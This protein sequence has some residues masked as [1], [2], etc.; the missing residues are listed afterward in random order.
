MRSITKKQSVGFV[1]TGFRHLLDEIICPA[2]YI[3][4][5]GA[6]FVHILAKSSLLK[7]FLRVILLDCFS[8]EMLDVSSVK[9]EKLKILNKTE[10][11]EVDSAFDVSAL[12]V[13]ASRYLL[14]DEKGMITESPKQMF[15]RIALLVA[16]SD[17]LHDERVFD[18][19][20]AQEK[21]GR[22]GGA[23]WRDA[24]IGKYILNPYHIDAF[25][26][27]YNEL[28]EQGCM[29]LEPWVI[30]EWPY[31]GKFDSYAARIKE[32]YD[33]MVNKDFLPN[34][35]TLMNAGAPLGQLSACFVLDIID[36]MGQIMDTAK[37][38]AMIFKSG[39]GVG[40]NYSSLR[41]EGDNVK[42]TSGV[43]SGPIS[44]MKIV[45]AVTD[46]VKQGGKRRGA[47]MGLLNASHPDIDKFVRI[48]TK[49]GVLENFNISMCIDEAFWRALIDDNFYVLKNPRTGA[50]VGARYARTVIN[51]I[52]Q[53]AWESAE[54]GL[55]FLD[56]INAHNPL[57]KTKGPITVCNPCGEQA[58]HPYESCNLGSINLANFV[59]NGEFD[60]ARY[61]AVIRLCTRFLDNVI[62]VNK[63]PLERI[64][65]ET[66]KTRRIGLGVMGLAD[67][68]FKLNIPYNDAEGYSIMDR[69][70]AHLS[71][72]SM[73][74]SVCL[75]RTRGPYPLFN[76]DEFLDNFPVAQAT[77]TGLKAFIRREGIRNAWTTTV[78][79]TGTLSMLANCSS[80]IEPVF[81]LSFEKHVT[82]GKFNYL[83]EIF[84]E[85]LR[86][87]HLGN[88]EL[89]ETIIKNYGSCKGL[90]GIPEEIQHVFVTSMDIHWADHVYAEAVWQKWISNAIA[91]T[92][93]M[94]A[95]ATHADIRRAY[96]LAH[97]LGLKGIT[98]YRDGSRHTQVLNI[99][100]DN[101][102]KAFEVAPSEVVKDA[103]WNLSDNEYIKDEL[104]AALDPGWC[105]GKAVIAPVIG[106]R[107]WTPADEAEFQKSMINKWTCSCGAPLV[108]SEGCSKCLSCNWSACSSG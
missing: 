60:W 67:A 33:L 73:A 6:L 75:A 94:P 35:P 32:Y 80:G 55:I 21:H 2:I 77:W 44:F 57:I 22:L 19:N 96:I 3:L 53:A 40:I 82:V 26:R 92:I 1:Y 69:M 42:S 27:L 93:N 108:I 91:K 70:A 95:D 84:M 24:P 99:A 106:G 23:T 87:L 98:V 76:A 83:N 51:N 46:V 39:G 9:E 20:G 107:I 65:T 54:P 48:K 63:Y 61:N 15:E 58:M 36:D 78:A 17:I 34:T 8:S 4:S 5:I 43:A 103:I 100:S 88:D 104:R 11:D 74:E 89:I 47:N 66:K 7:A 68:L 16:I 29:K 25:S 18:I 71:Y 97:E 56:N 41:P 13:L 102:V 30:T 81:G 38:V 59:V 85:K 90:Y 79:P 86:A 49:P 64:N 101:K 37:D 105:T 14:K 62:D 52:A 10:L 72:Q 31:Q 12:R 50:E 28:N 45:D